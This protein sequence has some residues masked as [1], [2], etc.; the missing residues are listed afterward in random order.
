MRPTDTDDVRSAISVLCKWLFNTKRSY[1]RR[2][3]LVEELESFWRWVQWRDQIN[4]QPDEP[5][6]L[7]DTG[8]DSG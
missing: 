4:Q 7:F 8:T 1:T 2:K 5:L 3:Q 6:S